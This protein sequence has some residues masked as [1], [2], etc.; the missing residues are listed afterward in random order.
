MRYR[1]Q[2]LHLYSNYLTGPDGAFRI[3]PSAHRV[4]GPLHLPLGR[5]NIRPSNVMS[6]RKAATLQVRSPILPQGSDL[7]T[8]RQDVPALAST[9]QGSI[10]VDRTC[11]AHSVDVRSTRSKVSVVLTYVQLARSLLSQHHS[12]HR[13]CDKRRLS[14]R[15]ITTIH[16]CATFLVVDSLRLT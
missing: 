8:A 12:L 11:K 15:Y 14:Q 4:S 7:M 3:V 9:W 13:T 16:R 10:V 2:P 1:T 5:R 6:A